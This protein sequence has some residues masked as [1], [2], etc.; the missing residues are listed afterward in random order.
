MGLAF[1]LSESQSKHEFNGDKTNS[2]AYDMGLYT[3]SKGDDATVSFVAFYSNYSMT[4]TRFV[5][6]GAASLPATGKPDGFRA[7]VE[8]AYDSKV[9]STPDSATYLRMGLGAGMMHRDAFR[10]TGDD[11]IAMNFDALNMP[12]FE[13]GM[14]MGYTTDLFED[15]KSWQL[16]GEGMFTRQVTGGNASVQ[17]RYNNRAGADITVASPEYTYMQFQP[18]IGVSWREGLGSAEFK[19]FAEIRGGKTAPGASASYKLRF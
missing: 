13:L 4:H 11:A 2:T 12:Y 3:A 8:L 15:D 7:G 14:G 19:V 17:A 5:D 16:F 9:F 6:M 10:E 18:S 1:G